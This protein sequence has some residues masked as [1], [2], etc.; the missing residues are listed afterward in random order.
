LA[1]IR[2]RETGICE[3]ALPEVLFDM[4]HPGHYMRRIKSVALTVPCV[5]GPY[6][7]LNCTLRLLEHKFRTNAIAKDKNDYLEKTDETDD[8][9]STVNVPITSIAVSSGQNDSGVFELNFKDERYIPFEGAGAISKW[10]IEL[11]VEFRQ[12]DYDTISDVILHL[13]YTT[14]D[15]G[16]KLKVPATAS[17]QQYIKGVEELSQQEGLFAAFDLKHDFPDE[18]YKMN[19]TPAGATER[20]LKLSNLFERLPIFTKGRLPA[21]ILATDMYLFTPAALAAST[22]VLT[23]GAEEITFTNGPPVGT[24]MKSFVTKDNSVAMDSWQLKIKDVKTVLDKLWLIVR[25]KI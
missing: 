12:F 25:Y 10:R 11:P 7:S 6:T 2:L 23:Q 22:L 9:F 13:R 18:W 14:V 19:N 5:V 21:K 20:L 16:D 3:F 24:T 4:D 15:G 17:V 1:F 8:R